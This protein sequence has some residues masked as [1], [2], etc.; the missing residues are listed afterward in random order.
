[1]IAVLEWVDG[2][3]YDTQVVG[4]FS[5]FVKAR[6]AFREQADNTGDYELRFTDFCIDEP[7]E[8]P[9]DWSESKK[10]FPKH[11]KKKRGNSNG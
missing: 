3:G 6:E 9:F 5:S 11:H 4:I 2:F 7:L 10:L 8:E 1:M